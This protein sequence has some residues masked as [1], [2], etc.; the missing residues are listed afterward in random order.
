MVKTVGIFPN[1]TKKNWKKVAEDIVE[2]LHKRKKSVAIDPAFL[3]RHPVK[4]VDRGRPLDDSDILISLGGDGTLLNLVKSVKNYSLPIIG[5]NLGALGFLTEFTVDSLFEGLDRVL[6]GD[7][8]IKKRITLRSVVIRDGRKT[9]KH[10]ALNDVVI[11]HQK[12]ARLL[13][14]TAFFDGTYVT[15][16]QADGLIIST[17]TGSTAYS[18]S[19]GGPIVEPSLDAILLTPICPH[20]LT[21]RPIMVPGNRSIR[22]VLPEPVRD[23][24]LTI[25]GQIGVPLLNG[26]VIEVKRSPRNVRIVQCPST[27]YFSVLRSKLGWSGSKGLDKI[28]DSAKI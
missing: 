13:T 7:Y 1:P 10:V 11:T 28:S 21:N 12:L 15:T 25:D 6:K 19:A 3:A 5:V 22:I 23:A 4:G 24:T 16:Y 26:D 20:T 2:F 18:L 9:A 14:I 27:S 17:P 8:T